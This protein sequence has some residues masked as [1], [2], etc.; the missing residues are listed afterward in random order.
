M[1]NIG[2]WTPVGN[3]TELR[4]LRVTLLRHGGSQTLKSNK[5]VGIRI[6]GLFVTCFLYESWTI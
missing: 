6:G 3:I 2:V 4:Q 1:N 5:D